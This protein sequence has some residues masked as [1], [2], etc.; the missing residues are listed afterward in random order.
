MRDGKPDRRG[1]R[2]ASAGDKLHGLPV[3]VLGQ[4]YRVEVCDV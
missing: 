3:F 2:F 4:L 1:T